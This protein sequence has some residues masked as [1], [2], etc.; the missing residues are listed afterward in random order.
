MIKERE[1]EYRCAA[2]LHPS[3]GG[4][5]LS[6]LFYFRQQVRVS[7]V[8]S[9]VSS[10]GRYELALSVAEI[11][12]DSVRDLLHVNRT[13]ERLDVRAPRA[14]FSVVHTACRVGLQPVA[15]GCNLSRRVATCRAGLQPVALR[16][17]VLSCAATSGAALQR[18]DCR[19]TC[20]L[21]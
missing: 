3:L 6:L 16:S 9:A 2:P 13:T 4:V 19:L 7:A 12:N 11:Y 15:S 20:R 21:G 14:V 18:L 10:A 8:A 17:G 1:G 5:G